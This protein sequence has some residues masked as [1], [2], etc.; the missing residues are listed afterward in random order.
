MGCDIHPY[1]EKK[2]G[3]N[4]H[5]Y[6]DLKGTPE[7]QNWG[8]GGQRDYEFFAHLC[9]VRAGYQ[10]DEWP[11]PKGLPEDVSVMCQHLSDM[12]DSDGH[13]HSWETLKDFVDK[14]LALIKIRGD[15]MEV[16]SHSREYYEYNIVGF[17]LDEDD[18][19]DDFRVVF[20]FDN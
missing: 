15:E 1:V 9:G 14:K 19:P 11:K 2:I 3:D 18:D 13:S 8:W 7:Y 20:W 17:S 16:G 10:D 4:W 6:A 5:M 12:W